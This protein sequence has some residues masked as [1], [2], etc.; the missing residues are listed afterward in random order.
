MTK[1]K[2]YTELFVSLFCK[3]W[4][5][6]H[7][8]YNRFHELLCLNKYF[9]EN[10]RFGKPFIYKIKITLNQIPENAKTEHPILITLKNKGLQM[11]IKLQ[12]TLDNNV[13]KSGKPGQPFNCLIRMSTPMHTKLINGNINLMLKII[14]NQNLIRINIILKKLLIRYPNITIY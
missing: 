2:C 7:F 14:L 10:N 12:T 13:N 9:L 3:N 8:L 4:E 6:W 11:P 1:I 5:F